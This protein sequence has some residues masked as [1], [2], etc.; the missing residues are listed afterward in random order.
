MC[1]CSRILLRNRTLFEVCT[2]AQTPPPSLFASSSSPTLSRQVKAYGAYAGYRDTSITP[3]QGGKDHETHASV[4]PYLRIDSLHNRQASPRQASHSSESFRQASHSSECDPNG[5]LMVDSLLSTSPG[6]CSFTQEEELSVYQPYLDGADSPTGLTD[7]HPDR[8]TH[9]HKD[10]QAQE[11]ETTA[12]ARFVDGVDNSIL[13]YQP[14]LSREYQESLVPKLDLR[15]ITSAS[16]STSK[17]TA[18]A[19]IER[20]RGYIA[21]IRTVSELSGDGMYMHSS[22]PRFYTHMLHMHTRTQKYTHTRAYTHAC[23]HKLTNTHPHIHTPCH[24]PYTNTHLT[25]KKHRRTEL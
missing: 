9:T 11:D 2:H 4:P 16:L 6:R 20:G 23:T 10:A 7:R 14:V 19:A 22:I 18:A 8:H 13:E 15:A 12:Y 3:R 24:A 25:H 1:W 21:P 5:F 17:H